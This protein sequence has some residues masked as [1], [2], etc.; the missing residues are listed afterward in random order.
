[1]RTADDAQRA[2]RLPRRGH[3]PSGDFERRTGAVTP[4]DPYTFI[5]TS[6]TT[7]PPK[8]CVITHANWSRFAT[9]RATSASLADDD[10]AYLYLPLA[11]VFALRPS[12]GALEM[13]STIVFFG[14]DTRAIIAGAR[15]AQP[16]LLA[17][18][19]AHLREALRARHAQVEQA[20]PEEREQFDKAVQIGLEVR[21][22]RR[23][24][25]R[26]PEAARAF[27]K[28][29]ERSSSTYARFLAAASAT[30]RPAP[31]RSRR[32]SSSSS[33]PGRHRPRGLGD[34]QDDRRRL[35]HRP[36]H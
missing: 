25:G 33:T 26:V 13:G 30:R 3:G 17:V 11:H 20:T 27:D 16:D 36:T 35:P 7:G 22:A 6:G 2:R 9:W 23:R 10:D 32:R 21:G 31:P 28:A 34:D 24:R 4:E 8:G 19:A 12:S 29:D 14:G 1:M 5:Y 18:G 15:G